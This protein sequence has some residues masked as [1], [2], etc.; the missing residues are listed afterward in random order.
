MR[1]TCIQ[2][3]HRPFPP[4]RFLRPSEALRSTKVCVLRECVREHVRIARVY[5]SVGVRTYV[6]T[7]A[8]SL[9]VCVYMYIACVHAKAYQPDLAE[10]GRLAPRVSATPRYVRIESSCPNFTIMFLRA[11]TYVHPIHIYIYILLFP[12]CN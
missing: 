12:D 10:K 8:R 2:M 4:R 11:Y 6:R 9:Y 3:F 5:V 7:L 1:A